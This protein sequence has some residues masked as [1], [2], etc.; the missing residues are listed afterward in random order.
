MCE[1]NVKKRRVR[2]SNPRTLLQVNG[3]QDHRNRP[4]CQLSGANI[5]IHFIL[6]KGRFAFLKKEF[7]LPQTVLN[8]QQV[9]V[10]FE[11]FEH[12]HKIKTLT[13]D[14]GISR[15]SKN[16]KLEQRSLSDLTKRRIVSKRTE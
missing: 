14:K 4:L 15:N 9:K 5:R 10:V 7:K 2:D 8:N 16:K 13:I 12:L 6:Q 3:F 11:S 1:G